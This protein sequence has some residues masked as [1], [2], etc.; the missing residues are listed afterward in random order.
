MAAKPQY[1][2]GMF[3][4]SLIDRSICEIMRTPPSAVPLLAG[5]YGADGRSAMPSLSQNEMK[6][7]SWVSSLSLV[8]RL[9]GLSVCVRTYDE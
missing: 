7:P 1:L 6:A 5:E 3:A 9:S 4:A 8:M 2:L